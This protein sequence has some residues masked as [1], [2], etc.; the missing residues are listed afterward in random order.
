MHSQP[1]GLAAVALV[2]YLPLTFFRIHSPNTPLAIVSLVTFSLVVGYGYQNARANTLNI[3]YGWSLAWRRFIM[4]MIG[5]TASF[6]F[7]YVAPRSTEKRIVRTICSRTMAETARLFS[8]ILSLVIARKPSKHAQ[9]NVTAN[10]YAVRSKLRQARSRQAYIRYEIAFTGEWS[11]T[12]QLKWTSLELV[13]RILAF[14][15]VQRHAHNSRRDGSV[16]C[17]AS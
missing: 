15:K 3:G 5:L 10:I 2:A 13:G 12:K 4:T 7:A 17:S 6:I 11:L 9:R 16:D 8:D 14:S 1:Y